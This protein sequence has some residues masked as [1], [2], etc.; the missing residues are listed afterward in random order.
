MQ[1]SI[2]KWGNSLGVRI[3]KHMVYECSMHSGST[4][5]IILKNKEIIIRSKTK[6]LDDLVNKITEKNK[7]SL[8]YKEDDIVGIEEW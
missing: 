8:Q 7:H 5:E 3:P 1:T 2:Q 6:S 4:V